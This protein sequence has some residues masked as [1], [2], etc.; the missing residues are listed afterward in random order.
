[1]DIESGKINSQSN[2]SKF[3][4]SGFEWFRDLIRKMIH[5]G[6]EFENKVEKLGKNDRRIIIHSLKVGITLAFVSLLFYFS[7]IDGGFK[8]ATMCA[9]LTVVVVFEF[10]VGA[11]LGKGLNRAIAT[12]LG[13]ALGIGVHHLANLAGEGVEPI[14]LGAFVFLLAA[15]ASFS[16]FFS[17]IKARYDYGVLTFILT[18]SLV[19]VSGYRIDEIEELVIH[20]FS[21]ILIGCLI[22]VL[23]SVFVFPVWAGEDLQKLT[24][25]NLE[26]LGDF[27]ETFGQQYYC[28]EKD[29]LVSLYLHGCETILNSKTAEESFVN[30]ARWEPPHG[31]FRYGHPWK[32]YLEIGRLTREC[33]YRIEA[34]TNSI[35]TSQTQPV[36]FSKMIQKDCMEMGIESSKA[37]KELSNSIK[38]MTHP[39]SVFTHLENL[40]TAPKNIKSSLQAC[41]SESTNIFELM[42]ALQV[43]SLLMEV[44][45]CVENIVDSVNE[46]SRLAK[47]EGS[48]TITCSDDEAAHVVITLCALSSALQSGVSQD[49]CHL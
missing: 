10:S 14:L 36:E 27:L 30:F 42:P 48:E 19:S 6:T 46:L 25:L 28:F 3:F 7:P 5:N 13:G 12:F 17:G 29:G 1:M 16:R 44:I 24:C 45:G 31:K 22:C 8:S 34:L 49:S 32:Q 35:K 26:N 23:I 11:T 4:E 40:M 20:R 38:M 39:E 21:T 2:N 18:F 15:V 41:T 43:T 33:A 9:I 47:F 37:L